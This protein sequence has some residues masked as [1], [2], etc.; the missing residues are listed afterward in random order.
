MSEPCFAKVAGIPS[1]LSHAGHHPRAAE[2]TGR[3]NALTVALGAIVILAVAAAVYFWREQRSAAF[4][5]DAAQA[6]AAQAERHFKEASEMIEAVIAGLA[7]N[8]AGSE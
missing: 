8:L 6:Q 3:G 7:D 5:R 4:Q 1:H 2:A